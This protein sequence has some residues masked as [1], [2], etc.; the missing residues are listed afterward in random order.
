[1]SLTSAVD[2]TDE[3]PFVE[4]D[5]FIARYFRWAQGEHVCFI[6]PTGSG[7]SVLALSL[8]PL[9]K[10]VIILASKPKDRSL[11][12]F[13]RHHKFRV[14]SRWRNL[15]IQRYP[16]RIIWPIHKKLRSMVALQEKVFE[17]TLD[18]VYE[19]GGWTL[20]G[21]E[22]WWLINQLGLGLHIK[23]FALQSRSL[24]ISLVLGLQR[25]RWVP[26][27]V[28][29]Q[30]THFF[31]YQATDSEDIR[32]LADMGSRYSEVVYETVPKLDQFECLYVRARGK[33]QM[34]VRTKAPAPKGGVK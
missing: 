21:D 25:P 32:R 26:L 23:T 15:S 5:E 28:Y 3:V 18:I 1:M 6:G 24:G 9:R 34:V 10:W 31:I 12:E 22:L 20:Y 8:L 19:D 11:E 2:V 17:E 30:S 4:W 16:R 7:K 33:N 27:E 13:A 14:L 29:T